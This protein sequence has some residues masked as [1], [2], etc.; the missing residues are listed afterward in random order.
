ME[1]L[2][3]KNSVHMPR[4]PVRNPA[5]LLALWLVSVP[6]AGYAQSHAAAAAPNTHT[7]QGR[8]LLRAGH[9]KEAESE[10][11]L[12]AKERGN[13]IEAQ[14]DLA[15]VHFAS[16]DYKKAR[17]VCQPLLSKAPDNAFSNLC[18]A[19]AFL[20]WRR[21]TRAAEYVEK[22][23]ASAPD[24]PEVYQVLGDLKR[25]EGDAAASLDAYRKAF[26]TGGDI[27]VLD[28]DSEFFQYFQGQQGKR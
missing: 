23:R 22:A 2:G 28:S 20:T 19:Q 12:A 25:I 1:P 27:M 15:R 13:S 9:I 8:A 17:S 14:Y 11:K 6:L 10:L 21:A 18:M 5:K 26:E 3:M 7:A 4:T 24:Q 16:G